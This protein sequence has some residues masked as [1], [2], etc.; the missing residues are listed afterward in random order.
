MNNVCLN[1]L[2]LN[3]SILQKGTLHLKHFQK[4]VQH[5]KIPLFLMFIPLFSEK[6]LA[7]LGMSQKYGR[8]TSDTYLK[9]QA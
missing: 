2:H 7:L 3:C 5:A 4:T 9:Q 1:G 6:E 8:Y